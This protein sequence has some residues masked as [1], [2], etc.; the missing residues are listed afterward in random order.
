MRRRPLLS[1]VFALAIA[2][3]LAGCRSPAPPPSLARLTGDWDVYHA[4]GT[5]PADGFEGWRR[6]AFAHFP[7]ADSNFL[8]TIRS[9]TGLSGVNAN[10][11]VAGLTATAV[12]AIGT[13]SVAID[14]DHATTF[15]ARWHN[16]TLTGVVASATGPEG[17]WRLVRRT[18]PAV[19]ESNFPLWPG[20][21]SDSQYAVTEDTLVFMNTR[22]GARLAC[23][24]ARPVGKGPFGVV[25]QRTPYTRILPAGRY[26]AS[27]GYIFVAQH[28]R[29]RDRLRRQ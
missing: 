6:T 29:G 14:G 21:V 20:A 27:R 28:V 11:A 10:G 12:H 5:T 7:A 18:A 26:W 16:D 3:T 9:R 15:R 22:D 1:L 25:L 19:A 23:Y 2:S 17:R 13:D 4:L 8:G 24:I